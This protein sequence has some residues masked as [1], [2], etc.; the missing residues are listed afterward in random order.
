MQ[1][2]EAKRRE[3]DTNT[4][5][6]APLGQDIKTNE[7]F[8]HCSLE[9]MRS[10]SAMGLTAVSM[11]WSAI[12]IDATVRAQ[13]SAPQRLLS[14]KHDLFLRPRGSG[15]VSQKQQREEPPILQVSVPDS[16]IMSTVTFPGIALDLDSIFVNSALI[17]A[18]GFSMASLPFKALADL[19][20]A[21]ERAE[22]REGRFVQ[23]K[24]QIEDLI[25][26]INQ[27]IELHGL[28]EENENKLLAQVK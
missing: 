14:P 10:L 16:S 5:L 22:A 21:L 2:L 26:F 20:L 7:D 9:K 15:T 27:Q 8:I 25:R 24:L 28:T 18:L 17:R 19:R 3:Q 12:A 23:E 11:I 4:L 6:L 1:Q 13:P